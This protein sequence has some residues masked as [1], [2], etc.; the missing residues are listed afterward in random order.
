MN[1]RDRQ[2]TAPLTTAITAKEYEGVGGRR[3][4]T[5]NQISVEH[6]FVDAHLGC[7]VRH[8]LAQEHE[9][10]IAAVGVARQVVLLYPSQ[11]THKVHAPSLDPPCLLSVQIADGQLML[12]SRPQMGFT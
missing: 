6:E 10:L 3:N 5:I 9:R 7:E 4:E 11:D 2:S 1:H 12:G 8:L